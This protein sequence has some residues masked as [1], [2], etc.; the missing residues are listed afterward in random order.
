MAAAIAVDT[1][2]GGGEVPAVIGCVSGNTV[3]IVHASCLHL[4]TA[5]RQAGGRF[6]EIHFY[7]RDIRTLDLDR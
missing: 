4:C 6:L 2:R 3:G 1:E 5:G 7:C